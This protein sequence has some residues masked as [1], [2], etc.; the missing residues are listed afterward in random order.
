MIGWQSNAVRWR[1]KIE[2][3][4]ERGYVTRRKV[5][6][7]SSSSQ[8]LAFHLQR[9]NFL[10]GLSDLCLVGSEGMHEWFCVQNGR[11]TRVNNCSNKTREGGATSHRSANS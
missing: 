5:G 11:D 10:N 6:Y 9:R 4:Y 2:L 3:D 7:P 8:S 1:S